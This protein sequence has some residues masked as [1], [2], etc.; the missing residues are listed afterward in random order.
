MD[1]PLDV[2]R[3]LGPDWTRQVWC[4]PV[5]GKGPNLGLVRGGA[6]TGLLWASARLGNK[7]LQTGCNREFHMELCSSGLEIG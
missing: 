6:K 7:R 4:L 1:Q 5:E 2:R 3:F